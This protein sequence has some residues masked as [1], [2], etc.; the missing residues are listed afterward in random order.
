MSQ[1][2]ARTLGRA[3]QPAA[4]VFLSQALEIASQKDR[5]ETVQLVTSTLEPNASDAL[6]SDVCAVM[7]DNNVQNAALNA[8]R[9]HRQTQPPGGNDTFSSIYIIIPG[10]PT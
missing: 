9:N 5:I 8:I 1:Q 2:I 6:L 7:M 3:R 10:T 4:L